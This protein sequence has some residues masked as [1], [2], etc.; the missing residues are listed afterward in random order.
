MI[1]WVRI[2]AGLL[3]IVCAVALMHSLLVAVLAMLWAF[4]ASPIAG[5]EMATG[6]VATLATPLSLTLGIGFAWKPLRTG[7]RSHLLK[8]AAYALFG[9]LCHI[10]VFFWIGN[11]PP[12][13]GAF[14]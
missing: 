5:A 7:K 13:P 10:S 8:A 14:R 9:L 6:V 2:L 12:N 4:P 11:L 3:I 1:P